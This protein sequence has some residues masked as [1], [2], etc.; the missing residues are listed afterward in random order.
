LEFTPDKRKQVPESLPLN[1]GA[2]RV[3]IAPISLQVMRD[4][5][6]GWEAKAD[7]FAGK[8]VRLFSIFI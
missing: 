2:E 6:G 3:Y 5:L 4:G 7:S 1:S 8:Q